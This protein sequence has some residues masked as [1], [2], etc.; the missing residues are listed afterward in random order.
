MYAHNNHFNSM[1]SGSLN[2]YTNY[3][4]LE[5]SL[6]LAND[7]IKSLESL[8][9]S[10]DFIIY[11][12]SMCNALMAQSPKTSTW[13]PPPPN[14]PPP[15][16]EGNVDADNCSQ[17]SASSV[18]SLN[19]KSKSAA[20][21][22][23]LPRQ[24]SQSKSKP[25]RDLK[26][27]SKAP[28]VPSLDAEHLRF[29]KDAQAHAA[30]KSAVDLKAAAD[31]KVAYELKSAA[32]RKSLADIKAAADF[33][34]MADMTAMDDSKKAPGVKPSKVADPEAAESTFPGEY[35][36]N[37]DFKAGV[38]ARKIYDLYAAAEDLR[39]AADFKAAEDS[40]LS[41]DSKVNEDSRLTTYF[42]TADDAAAAAAALKTAAGSKT[43]IT[44]ADSRIAA[45]LKSSKK[46]HHC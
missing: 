40:C 7:R 24:V 12:M 29:Y 10:K 35:R 23:H 41:A 43:I 32:D 33:K 19:G 38:D 28:Q 36:D 25:A 34:T 30:I 44:D 5:N 4:R 13:R 1:P 37:A 18:E 11:H 31:F 20:S 9:A 27:T 3:L 2:D 46:T 26:S 45:E 15:Q 16:K 21:T 14:Y 17:S 8:L 22:G 42:K 6:L 39:L